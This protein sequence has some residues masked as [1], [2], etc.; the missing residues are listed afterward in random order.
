MT[1]REERASQI[2]SQIRE[3]LLRD[4]DPIGVQEETRAQDEYDGYV[5]GVYRLLAAGASPRSVAEHL[6][7]VEAEQMGLGVPADK[8]MGVATKLC[9]L[10]VKL[11]IVDG[12]V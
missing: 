5:G 4:W 6:A 12:A 2:Q 7:H 1:S 11:R 3:I 8:L 9:A 10:D